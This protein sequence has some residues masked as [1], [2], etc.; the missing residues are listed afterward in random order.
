ML[1]KRKYPFSSPS[2]GGRDGRKAPRLQKRAETE[3][4]PVDLSD[5]SSLPLRTI[6]GVRKTV[7]EKVEHGKKHVFRALKK[8]KGFEKQ[9]LVK[10]LK[11][12][13]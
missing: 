12:A 1:P 8:A 3:E 7:E 13:R 5:P 10:R 11:I 4:P 9:K 2:H 6:E